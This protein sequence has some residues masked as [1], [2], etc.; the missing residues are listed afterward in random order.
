MMTRFYS[1]AKHFLIGFAL[2]FCGS[3]ASI[4][5]GLVNNG[6]KI[7]ITA[8]TF[9]VVDNGGFTNLTGGQIA[10]AGTMDVDGNWS[11]SDANGNGV[12][13]T[14]PSAGTVRLDGNSA[15]TIGGTE[16]TH[17]YNL[18]INGTGRKSLT[19]TSLATGATTHGTITLTGQSLELNKHRLTVEN[20]VYNTAFDPASTGFVISETGRLAGGYGVVRWKMGISPAPNAFTV[21]FGTAGVTP[22]SIP[23]TYDVVTAGTA[24]SAYKTF[25]TYGTN[26]YNGFL[27]GAAGTDINDYTTAPLVWNNLPFTVNH[28]TD[29]YSQA[30]HFWVVDRYWIIDDENMGIGGNGLAEGTGGDD[31]EYGTLTRPKV[32]YTFNY[33]PNE[34]LGSNHITPAKITPQ[35]YNHDQNKWGDWMYSDGPVFTNDPTNNRLTMTLG[36]D[37][38][39]WLEDAY[40]V[41]TLVDNSDPL[42]IELVR[43]AGECGDGSIE[44]KWTTWTETNNDF[45]TVERSNNGTDFEVVDVIEGAGNSN[46]SITY[47]AIDNLPYG[48]TSYYRLKNTDF[49]GKS[50]YSEIIAVTCGTDGNDFNFVNAYDVDQTDIVVEFTA[51]DNEKF[52]IFLYDASG[53]RTLD[54]SGVGVDGMNKVRLPAGGLA[55]GIYII[56]LSNAQRNFSKRVMLH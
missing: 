47:N 13:G 27:G 31:P 40:P 14:T 35:R 51:A 41:W 3:T 4:A 16:E 55:R 2:V 54:F 18:T 8:N 30:S 12:F 42:P 46:Q 32:R 20:G 49:T 17:F 23:F 33:A 50:E 5:Q 25:A 52:T 6:A 43:F 45:F 53:R 26:E 19:G 1:P 44:L 7:N 10:N 15:Q 37:A 22:I 28:L 34:R 21:P 38:T 48:G 11:N 9:L 24:P 36:L 56:N 29:D 39:T